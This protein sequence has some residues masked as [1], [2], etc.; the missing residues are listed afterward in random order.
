MLKFVGKRLVSA[1]FV[2]FGATIITFILSRVIPSD[3]ALAFYGPKATLDQSAR[4]RK[5]MGLDQS[6]VIQYFKY[7]KDMLTGNWGYSISTKQPVLHE[8]MTKVPS[9]LEMIFVSI[10]FATLFG[11]LLGIWAAKNAHKFVDGSVRVFSIAAVSLPTFWL[12]LLFQL[13]FVGRLHWFPA[14]GEFDTELKFLNPIKHVTG[15]PIFDALITGNFHAVENGLW[16]MVLPALT[17]SL[18]SLGLISR[19]IRAN[20]LEVLSQDYIRVARAYG[21]KERVVL[22]T[23][24]LRNALPPVTTVVGLSAAYLL[25]GT[26]FVEDVFNWPGIGKFATTA[27]LNVD[28][29]AIMGITLLGA[30]GYLT[31][32]LI[33]D[34]VQAKLDPRVRSE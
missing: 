17:L 8:L 25:T 15:F 9:T 33:V 2:L 7:L 1:L 3:P 5:E 32:N 6:V 29:P 31:I 30:M 26:F 20:L 10:I 22:F 23:L 11:I 4:L 13:F 27:L 14:T 12:G 19:M 21:I 16:H 24:A 18:Y 28:Y 34:I